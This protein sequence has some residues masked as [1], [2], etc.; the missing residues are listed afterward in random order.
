MKT[1][2]STAVN[3]PTPSKPFGNDS[4][5]EMSAH[6]VESDAQRARRHDGQHDRC[7]EQRE[8]DDAEQRARR[9]KLLH[10]LGEPAAGEDRRLEEIIPVAHVAGDARCAVPP[11]LPGAQEFQR[12]TVAPFVIRRDHDRSDQQDGD[13]DHRL[14]RR[15]DAPLVLS[16]VFEAESRKR[17]PGRE[18]ASWPP[19]PP[20]H[21]PDT[22]ASRSAKVSDHAHR[23][24]YSASA[25]TAVKK[26]ENGNTAISQIVL[27]ATSRPARAVVSRST[28]FKSQHERHRRHDQRADEERVFEIEERAKRQRHDPRHPR[29]ERK[30]VR[31]RKVLG[32]EPRMRIDDRLVPE[33]V[34]SHPA[35]DP[36]VRRERQPHPRFDRMRGKP[37]QREV[38][39]GDEGQPGRQES[40]M[41]RLHARSAGAPPA[42]R[43]RRHSPGGTPTIRLKL[44]LNAASES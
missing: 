41:T 42:M 10:A 25:Y 43:V 1:G 17:G 30:E 22:S 28:A 21:T 33:R 23:Q 39:G 14:P 2:N 15:A 7:R 44:R 13:A 6:A 12:I 31:V 35:V 4:A 9:R 32:H 19:W 3:R 38:S 34:P 27:T 16:Q 26:N 5:I 29:I 11:D 40:D 37:R 24:K 36:V 18:C 20:A 8:V